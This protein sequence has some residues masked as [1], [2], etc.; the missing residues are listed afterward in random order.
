M[1]A[2]DIA[3]LERIAVAATFAKAT[4]WQ[5]RAF[6]AAVTP[7]VVLSLLAVVRAAQ[8]L[9]KQPRPTEWQGWSDL[10]AA[11]EALD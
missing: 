9:E 11:L 2:I 7:A 10:Y 5:G 4:W 1:T 3:E 6:T 8:A